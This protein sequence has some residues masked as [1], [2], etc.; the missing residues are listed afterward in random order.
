MVE[1]VFA[2]RVGI[3][4]VWTV[5]ALLYLQGCAGTDPLPAAE[6]PAG[7]A[8]CV[9]P[10]PE[11][12]TQDYRPVC[13]LRDTGVRCVTTPCESTER[14][15]YGNACAACSNPGVVGYSEGMCAE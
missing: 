1:T 8:Q 13:G 10:R 15:T 2:S 6:L 11:L 3:K 5:A 9:D 12:C 14:V 4:F 7:L